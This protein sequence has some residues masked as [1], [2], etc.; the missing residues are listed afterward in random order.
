MSDIVSLMIG[1]AIK[2]GLDTVL[3]MLSGIWLKFLSRNRY[4]FVRRDYLAILEHKAHSLAILMRT[5]D[6]LQASE[7]M[8]LKEESETSKW[9]H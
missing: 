2:K 9:S 5:Y 4:V 1:W 6:E 3:G 8:N 7:I